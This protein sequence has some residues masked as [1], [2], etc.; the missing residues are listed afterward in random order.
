MVFRPGV[1]TAGN[2]AGSTEQNPTTSVKSA[3]SNLDIPAWLASQ[4]E[5]K[6][7]TGKHTGQTYQHLLEEQWSYVQWA[8]ETTR[9][10]QKAHMELKVLGNLGRR[11]VMEAEAHR[12]QTARVRFEEDK[13][14]RDEPSEEDYDNM[15]YHEE[16]PDLNT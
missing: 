14:Q 7:A 3:M 12:R 9:A 2:L 4:L 5:A 6:L 1:R 8:M 16:D 10:N 15:E 13:R 11:A